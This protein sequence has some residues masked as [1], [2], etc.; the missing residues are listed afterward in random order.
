MKII[1]SLLFAL[2]LSIAATTALAVDYTVDLT[3]QASLGGLDDVYDLA[4][5]PDGKVVIGGAFTQ[6]GGVTRRY[7]AR[8]NV[9]GSLD[10]TFMS[11]LTQVQT[12]P[13][14]VVEKIKLLPDGKFLIVG[15]FQ[16]GSQA[17][18]YARLNS[19]GSADPSITLGTLGETI[20]PW[21]IE[22]LP[23]GKFLVCGGG[24]Q[25]A[26][27]FNGDGTVDASFQ[28]TIEGTCYRLR[29]RADGKIF[30]A[31]QLID[32]GFLAG[33]VLLMNS[34]GSR[35]ASFDTVLP[36]DAFANVDVVEAPDGKLWVNYIWQNQDRVKR[37]MPDGSLDLDLPN[38]KSRNFLPRGDGST[39]MTHCRKPGSISGQPWSFARIM[40][41]G[42]FD[43]SFDWLG[44]EGINFLALHDG[45]EGAVY[46]TGRVSLSTPDGLRRNVIRLIPDT[47]PR[48][49]RFDFDGDG[50]SDISVFRPSDRYWYINRSTAGP[51]YV[52]WGLT[53]D[54]LAAGHYDGD[55]KTDIG[56]FRDGIWHELSS[57][58]G[59][60][61]TFLGAAG[62]RP[63]FGD[64]GGIGS[65]SRMLRGLRSGTPA[66][67]FSTSNNRVLQGELMSDI[68]V[69]GDFEGDGRDEIGYFRDGVWYGGISDWTLPWQPRM[70]WGITGDI[71]VPGDYD[72]DR[73]TDYAVFRPSTGVWWINRST[74]GILALK[75]GL[76]GDVPVPADYDGDGKLDI[77]I[78]R[79]GE[80]WQIQSS[81]GTVRVDNW[82]IAGDIPIPAQ[83]Q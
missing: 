79:N 17:T 27:R 11:P 65:E 77:A 74:A 78:F 83:N 41:N 10:T 1:C 63:M 7:I 50:R 4:V 55:G 5:Q 80:W 33:P 31:G 51:A 29:R 26:S 53:T 37:L 72:G 59:Y 15:R 56:V 19:D 25:A 39:L 40:Q 22:P 62:D 45:P 73:Q 18:R 57:V 21:E 76:N 32:G 42:A 68:P 43:Q 81:T 70:Q 48:K 16:V 46:V 71:P 47:V 69:I 58:S 14:G 3:F 35:D 44:I 8:L 38:C 20:F 2:V 36:D 34:D 52:Q 66:W 12:D 30:I 64:F 75:F 61:F 82:G 9:D 6:I 49:A 28:S 23:D 60:I 24:T 67:I 13:D 54:K